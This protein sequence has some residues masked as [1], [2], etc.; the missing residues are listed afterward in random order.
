EKERLETLVGLHNLQGRVFLLGFVDDASRYLK[1][2]DIFLLPSMTEGLALV[3]LEAGLAG[4]PVVASRI[5]GIPEVIEDKNTG[6]LVP[7]RDSDAIALANQ[8]LMTDR[9]LAKRFGE[10]LRERVL[11]KFPLS[12]VLKDT[13]SLYTKN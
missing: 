9:S 2:F 5:G 8:N 10:A 1:A 4:L 6:L 11:A 3:L 13:I 12:R 7:T